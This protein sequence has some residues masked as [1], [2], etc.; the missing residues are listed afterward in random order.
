MPKVELEAW[1]K[2][3]LA[4]LFA[5]DLIFVARALSD[6]IEACVLT[7]DEICSSSSADMKLSS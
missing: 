3:T 4:A 5:S 1:S 2:S 7:F 6:E